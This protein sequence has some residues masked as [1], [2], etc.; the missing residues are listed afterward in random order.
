MITATD[1]ASWTS[2]GFPTSLIDINTTK[3]NATNVFNTWRTQDI[4][5]TIPYGN[6]PSSDPPLPDR[7][8]GSQ[9]PARQRHRPAAR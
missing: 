9:P 8:Q 2:F 1:L 6:V 5:P 4:R 7:H 3:I